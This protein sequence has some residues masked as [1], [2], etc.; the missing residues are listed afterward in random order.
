MGDTT[1]TTFFYNFRNTYAIVMKLCQCEPNLVANI[2]KLKR[3]LRWPLSIPSFFMINMGRNLR[4]QNL[5]RKTIL[6]L[7]I[8]RSDRLETFTSKPPWQKKLTDDIDLISGVSFNFMTC[9]EVVFSA[10]GGIVYTL[11][12]KKNPA[13]N[14]E[15][16]IQLWP[17]HCPF[18]L[19][20]IVG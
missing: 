5:W 12:L 7:G 3:P 10:V 8:K 15:K 17:R 11:P 14:L 19:I 1:W 2:L 6:Y 20:S 13:P 18:P 16:E 4:D 9:L